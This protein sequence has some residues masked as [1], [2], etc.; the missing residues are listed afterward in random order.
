MSDKT[1]V[2]G[3]DIEYEDFRSGGEEV[4]LKRTLPSVPENGLEVPQAAYFKDLVE[5]LR[6]KS[7]SDIVAIL[8][9]REAEETHGP[10]ESTIRNVASELEESDSKLAYS[11]HLANWEKFRD[12]F[13]LSRL[14]VLAFRMGNKPDAFRFA[15]ISRF[16]GENLDPFLLISEVDFRSGGALVE[17]VLAGSIVEDPN[18]VRYLSDPET[19]RFLSESRDFDEEQLKELVPNSKE[20]WNV[21]LRGFEYRG[22][23][24]LDPVAANSLVRTLAQ[25]A[26]GVADIDTDPREF[27]AEY[28]SSAPSMVAE[29]YYSLISE[30]HSVSTEDCASV[31]D[32][33]YRRFAHAIEH[34][35]DHRF[36]EFHRNL[37]ALCVAMD[38]PESVHACRANVLDLE[39]RRDFY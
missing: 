4:V 36:I 16:M 2:C 6:T 20:A 34:F 39:K 1:P 19:A 37:E 27:L 5:I 17:S 18:R 23:T 31:G 12:S 14:I 28:A 7:A 21:R 38:H 3:T 22:L 26:G 25:L 24:L 29:A 10:A 15:R 8:A 32:M 11:L 9:N 13:S 33:L 30:G 35:F